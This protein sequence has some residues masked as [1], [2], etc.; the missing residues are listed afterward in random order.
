MLKRHALLLLAVALPSVRA[1]GQLVISAHSGLVE[2][3]E[4][5]VFID[6]QPLAPNRG[7]FSEVGR[8]SVLRTESG[9]AEVLLTPGVYLRLNERSAIR[10]MSNRLADTRIGF[11]NGSAIV[12]STDPPPGNAVTLI[13]GT[14][15]IRLSTRGSYRLDS[16]PSRITVS[17]GRAEVS[18][19]G[20]TIAIG[21]SRSLSFSSNTVTEASPNNTDAFDRWGERRA[22]ATRLFIQQ[23]AVS[24]SPKR[25]STARAFPRVR[26]P[27]P[28]RTW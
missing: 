22:Q 11:L 10:M 26:A 24:S 3:F 17:S 25:R 21:E 6:D 7:R 5:R 18:L 19:A 1:F 28:R 8:N 9:R 20:K 4:G 14:Y 15:Q 13:Y 2:Y 27:L 23:A 16:A 12:D